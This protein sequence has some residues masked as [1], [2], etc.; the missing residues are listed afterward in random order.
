MEGQLSF[1]EETLD[2]KS[3]IVKPALSKQASKLRECLRA[4]N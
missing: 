1:L 3:Q 4:K 2:T